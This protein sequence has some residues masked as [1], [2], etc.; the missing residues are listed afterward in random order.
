[1]EPL[2]GLL[3]ELDQL[4][5]LCTEHCRKDLLLIFDECDHLIKE[6]HF[7]ASIT[8]ILQLCPKC[9]V[10]L[11]TQEP[12]VSPAGQFKFAHHRLSGISMK[13][14][15]KLFLRRTHR[16]LLWGD[17][18]EPSNGTLAGAAVMHSLDSPVVM[19]GDDEAV[20]KQVYWGAGLKAQGGNPQKI[21]DLASTF[22]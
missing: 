18:T 13:W 21:I 20:A 22:V 16:A 9:R 1:V 2:R 11:S 6:E 10:L 8:Q 7:Q 17:L 3:T 12:M 19:T 4:V 14:A 15:V 5:G